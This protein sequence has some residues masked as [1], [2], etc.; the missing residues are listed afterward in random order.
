MLKDLHAYDIYYLSALFSSNT[1]RIEQI[2]KEA[3]NEGYG[4][5]SVRGMSGSWRRKS[6]WRSC[7]KAVTCIGFAGIIITLFV[8]YTASYF[9]I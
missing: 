8:F 2:K 3:K 6:E 9:S 7:D 5:L 4:L 1:L